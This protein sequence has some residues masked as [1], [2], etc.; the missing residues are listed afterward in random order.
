MPPR[1][2]PTTA[3][4][5]FLASLIAAAPAAQAQVRI[6]VPPAAADAP[7][8]DAPPTDEHGR[9]ISRGE[10]KALRDFQ[11]LDADGDGRLSR[12]EVAFL[13]PLA[14][15]FDQADANHDGY[16]DKDELRAF[17]AVYRAQRDAR[18]AAEA[19]RKAAQPQ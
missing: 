5:L 8:T 14:A 10:Q 12:S 2:R 15:A 13:P 7:A 19:Q 4:L 18:R 16:V 3:R 11:M 17:S 1:F 6:E 9:P